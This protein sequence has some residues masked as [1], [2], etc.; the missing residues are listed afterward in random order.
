MG[1]RGQRLDASCRRLLQY[2]GKL[3]MFNRLTYLTMFNRLTYM[4]QEILQEFP[5]RSR[6]A[7]AYELLHP[8]VEATAAAYQTPLEEH[9]Q[10]LAG[11]QSIYDLADG[12]AGSNDTDSVTTVETCSAGQ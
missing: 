6:A 1:E 4:T 12:Q 10:I 11:I 9:R 7:H 3:L 8:L 5:G 2:F